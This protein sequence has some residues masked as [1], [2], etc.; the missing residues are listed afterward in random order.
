[1]DEKLK[2]LVEKDRSRSMSKEQRAEQRIGFAFGN[3]PKN[4]KNTRETIREISNA[5]SGLTDTKP[6]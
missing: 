5:Q 4:D 2:A 1:M 3:A 6:A